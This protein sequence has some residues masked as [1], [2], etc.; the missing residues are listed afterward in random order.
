MT[1]AVKSAYHRMKQNLVE[2][3]DVM[4]ETDYTYRLT[5]PQRWFGEWIEH[6]A[7]GNDAHCAAML[8]TAPPEAAKALSG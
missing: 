4:P 8:G 5:S 1:G 2:I 6:T 7:A 3:A